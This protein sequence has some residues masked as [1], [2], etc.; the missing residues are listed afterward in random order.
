MTSISNSAVNQTLWA[1]KWRES[2]G[3]MG[4]LCVYGCVSD[5]KW[6]QIEKEESTAEPVTSSRSCSSEPGRSSES[7]SWTHSLLSWT[8]W[9]SQTTHRQ[10]AASH[11]SRS[12]C[13]VLPVCLYSMHAFMLVLVRMP[14][15]FFS[16]YISSEHTYLLLQGFFW[17]LPCCINLKSCV[18]IVR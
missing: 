18:T 10:D 9:S 8:V 5:G 4:V 13:S 12:L 3:L 2:P 1:N 14:P 11:C 6:G 16:A 15:S 17:C 7:S